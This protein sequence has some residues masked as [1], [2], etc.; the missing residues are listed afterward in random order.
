MLGASR[1]LSDAN[2]LMLVFHLLP[3]SM[4]KKKKEDSDLNFPEVMLCGDVKLV[5]QMFA[6]CFREP[7]PS[8]RRRTSDPFDSS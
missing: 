4:K 7:P 1:Q 2:G 8:C 6:Q 5:G 3:S